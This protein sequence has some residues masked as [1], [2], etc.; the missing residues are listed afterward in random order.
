VERGEGEGDVKPNG[1]RKP[2]AGAGFGGKSHQTPNPTLGRNPESAGNTPHLS[3]A[4]GVGWRSYYRY[5]HR[6]GGIYIWFT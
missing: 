6:L 3:G 1:L 5:F 4:R 2:R